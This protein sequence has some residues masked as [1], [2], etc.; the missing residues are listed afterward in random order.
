M[1]IYNCQYLNQD[2]ATQNDRIL[3]ENERQVYQRLQAKSCY[4]LK[5][6]KEAPWKTY[7]YKRFKG[8]ST[9]DIITFVNQLVFSLDSGF[10]ILQ[11]L[12]YLEEDDSKSAMISFTRELK[13][14]LLQGMTFAD[15]L[16]NTTFLLPDVLI[17]WVQIGEKNGRLKESL[18]EAGLFLEK[19][20]FVRNNLKSQ[21]AYPMLVFIML[22]VVANIM[23]FI[24]MP[25]LLQSFH[26]Y[27]LQV[28]WY[29]SVMTYSGKIL[30]I[31]VFV[32]IVFLP[33]LFLYARYT[34]TKD[35]RVKAFGQILLKQ[36]PAIKQILDWYYYIPF[37]RSFS[38][39]LNSGISASE[40]LSILQ[41]QKNFKYHQCEI[42]EAMDGISAGKSLALS[43]ESCSFISKA[44][45]DLIALGERT[46]K[47]AD[48]LEQ[49]AAH[50]EQKLSLRMTTITKMIEPLAILVL[51]LMVLFMALSLMLPMLDSYQTIAG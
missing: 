48:V 18:K 20:H 5:I 25:A 7:F 10:S 1:K 44:A 37:A 6:K 4:S 3:A 29:V 23:V 40:A 26:E 34:N 51:G 27:Y 47:C 46:G 33:F 15:A 30:L 17:Q 45:I 43:F 12:H 36:L 38:Q 31:M 16:E 8:L 9:E 50:Y 42:G 2:G 19:N 24:V 41:K 35:N 39:L 28:P 32:I 11:A 13:D 49:S 14:N 21:L 22:M